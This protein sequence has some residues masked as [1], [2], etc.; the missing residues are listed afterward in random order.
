MDT[1]NAPAVPRRIRSPRERRAS[2]RVTSL[3]SDMITSSPLRLAERSTGEALDEPVQERVVEQ[4]ERDAG[5]QRRRHQR[6]P[7]EDVADDQIGRDPG[8]RDREDDLAQRAQPGAAVDE[9]GV[10]ELLRDR[11]EEPHQQ[12]GRERDR[13]RGID[14]D[15]RPERVLEA[16]LRNEAGQRQEEQ[17][18]RHEVREEDA[19][20]NA[21]PPPA[22]EAG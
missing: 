16:Q 8:Q 20:A 7:V 22:R 2:S 14:Q 17:R 11:L 21:L 12:P 3:L 10:L 6:L 9:R 15:Q 19:D 1:A 13:E 4:R 18:R 5:N